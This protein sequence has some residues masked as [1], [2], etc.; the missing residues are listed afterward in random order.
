MLHAQLAWWESLSGSMRNFS[1]EVIHVG[2]HAT[3]RET[4]MRYRSTILGYITTLWDTAAPPGIRQHFLEHSNTS[5]DTAAFSEMHRS[6][7]DTA[8]LPGIQQHFL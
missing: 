4:D 7:R 8:A 2:S 1:M 6:F 3:E 5:W